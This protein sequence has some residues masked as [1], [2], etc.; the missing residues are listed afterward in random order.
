M[1]YTISITQQCNLRC[2]YCYIEKNNSVMSTETAR[3]I[4]NNIYD[5]SPENEKIDIGFFGGEPLLEFDLVKS[6]VH[7]IKEHPKYNSKLV[8][9]DLVTNGTIFSDEIGKF[10]A[11]HDISFCLS[12]DGPPNIQDKFRRYK[13][14]S[15]S[16]ATV[17]NTI[18][19]VLEHL[20][21]I[22]VNAVYTPETFTSLPETIEYFSSLG[23]K[24]IYTN[25]D[26]S[27][28]WSMSDA[29]RLQQVYDQIA[30]QYMDYYIAGDPHYINLIDNKIMLFLK[31]GYDQDDK[32]KM[33]SGEFAFTPSGNIY[34]CERLIGADDG[35]TH[36]IGNIANGLK[37]VRACDKTFVAL[38][39][40]TECA[41]C[42]V[43]D[44]CMN[45][46]G[47]SNIFASGNY[48]RVGAFQC[49]SEKAAVATAYDIF[50]NLQEKIG[51]KYITT[52][53][54][55]IASYSCKDY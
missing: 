20:P 54:N 12:C 4:I 14:G 8:E 5:H 24:R 16:S 55:T 17:K 19:R 25:P 29:G 33:G 3:Q 52:F 15:G 30:R 41:D 23:L 37:S 1:K 28:N 34:P 44:Y 53:I 49:A 42:S 10:F 46:C 39:S 13:D 9:I 27:A 7:L 48:N 31:D 21:Y 22:L 51:P 47:C 36:C 11:K 6:I 40:N 2:S 43:S 45:W 35:K 26:F 38:S 50:N 18:K 32:C